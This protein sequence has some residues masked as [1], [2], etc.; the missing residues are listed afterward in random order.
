MASSFI[1]RF[2]ILGLS[3]LCFDVSTLAQVKKDTRLKDFLSR[4][5]KEDQA[6]ERP[7]F[8]IY[9]SLGYAPETSLD[10]SLFSAVY[11]HAKKD[12]Q[13]SRLSEIKA[14]GFY[15]L[16]SQYGLWIEN[17]VNTNKNRW[18]L[19]G[20][21]R[22]HH[23]PMFYYG[24]GPDAPE[25]DPVLVE[26]N[27]ILT[28]QR[29]LRNIYGHWFAGLRLDLQNLGSVNFGGA[30]PS[31]P[32]PLG[33]K[34][35]ANFGV[36]PSFVFDS[37][38]NMLNSRKGWFGEL[39]WLHYGH[40]LAS[41]YDM[42]VFS[43]DLRHYQPLNSRMVLAGQLSYHVVQGNAPFNMLSLM[44]NEMLMRGYYT[45][46]FRDKHYYAAQAEYRCLPFP[47]SHRIGGT[48]FL[49]AG[50]VSPSL[51]LLS[52]RQIRLAGGIGLRYLI[53]PKKDVFMR[54]DAGFTREGMGV[55]FFTGEAF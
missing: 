54:L 49:S 21:A 19:Y 45:G 31:R 25:A 15:T 42:E 14:I 16:Q 35:S 40:E 38:S 46:R 43:A 24:I 30:H 33:A 11:F 9:P 7:R 22:F 53:F 1:Q 36:G 44:G 10:I 3:L 27:Q 17:T 6:P 5:T 55:Y 23:F 41:D 28:R 50:E 48:L 8:L 4:L 51:E 18:L 37:R 12:L 32:L 13:Y 34:G 26:G 47:F 20:R 2:L 52:I 29:A 39:S